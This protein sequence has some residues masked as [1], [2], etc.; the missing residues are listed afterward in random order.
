[1]YK[2][3]TPGPTQVRENVRNARSLACTNPDL[4]P[5]FYDYYK[6]TCELISE[7]LEIQPIFW[8]GKEF[9]VWRQLVRL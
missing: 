2:I 3:M 8:M 1:M 6:E 9:L 7:L 5:A 4:D